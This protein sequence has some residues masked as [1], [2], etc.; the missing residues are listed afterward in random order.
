MKVMAP[1]NTWKEIT[2]VNFHAGFTQKL[3]TKRPHV[4]VMDKLNVVQLM[5]VEWEDIF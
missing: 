3:G 4:F 5:N 2:Q 1:A